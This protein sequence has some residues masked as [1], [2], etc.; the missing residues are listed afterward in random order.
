MGIKTK[1]KSR[2]QIKEKH[3]E[4]ESPCYPQTF[5]LDLLLVIHFNEQKIRWV[6]T[7]SL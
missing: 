4:N 6:T 7:V 3:D 2:L 1:K 5:F